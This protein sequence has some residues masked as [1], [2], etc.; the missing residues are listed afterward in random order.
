MSVTQ[1]QQHPLFI[2]AQRKVTDYNG[3]L[4]EVLSKFPVLVNFEQSTQVPKTYV[5]IGALLLAV[6]LHSFNVF[7]APISNLLL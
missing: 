5:I 3:Q 2:Q 7:A 1:R 6:F 4:D